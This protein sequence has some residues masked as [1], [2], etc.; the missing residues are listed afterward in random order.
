VGD[1]TK[2]AVAQAMAEQILADRDRTAFREGWDSGLQEALNKIRSIRKYTDISESE[3]DL[4]GRLAADLRE[5]LHVG[6]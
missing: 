1:I 6:F 4:L 2:N 5:E 3:D